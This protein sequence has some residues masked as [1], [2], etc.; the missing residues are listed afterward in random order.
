MNAV[1]AACRGYS[2]VELL[3]VV[4]IIAVLGGLL[5]PVLGR[6]REQGRQAGCLHNLQQLAEATMLAGQDQGDRLPT[7]EAIWGELALPAGVRRCPT[8]GGYVY[9]STLAGQALSQAR[10]P[11]GVTSSSEIVLFADGRAQSPDGPVPHVAYWRDDFDYRHHRQVLVAYLDGHAGR[12]KRL[13]GVFANRYKEWV[14]WDFSDGENPFTA[15][16]LVTLADGTQA[17]RVE[18]PAGGGT[19]TEAVWG[20]TPTHPLGRYLLNTLNRPPSDP[21][22][23]FMGHCQIRRLAAATPSTAAPLT[24][25][26]GVRPHARKAL[27]VWEE[28][29]TEWKCSPPVQFSQDARYQVPTQYAIPPPTS[30]DWRFVV[31][32]R[33]AGYADFRLNL[34]F[35]IDN[36]AN[37]APEAF[38]LDDLIIREELPG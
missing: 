34:T 30:A 21:P 24:C 14:R 1:R 23:T 20:C 22:V 35:T 7:P 3:V 16:E 8:G 32:P 31:T 29:G 18:E 4:G 2:L 28:L 19:H 27:W 11:H 9:N 5:F 15:A 25:A 33:E 38:L 26:A 36:P 12:S 13:M 6:A 37:D 10:T 17:V